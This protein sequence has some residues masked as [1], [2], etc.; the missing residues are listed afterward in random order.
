MPGITFPVKGIILISAAGGGSQ[1]SGM[2]LAGGAVILVVM[3]M[4]RIRSRQAQARCNQVTPEEKIASLRKEASARDRVDATM[5]EV[6]EV[7]RECVARLENKAL[8]LEHLLDLAEQRIREMNQL[9]E[10]QQKEQAHEQVTSQPSEA[11]VA[12]R[13]GESM[14]NEVAGTVPEKE[15]MQ[16]DVIQPV[17]AEPADPL[18][19]QI[20]EMADKGATPVQIAKE[21]DEQVGKVELI[22]ALRRAG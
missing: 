1:L 7:T 10:S 6:V 22:L 9:L 5:S 14:H 19:R 4:M 18:T 15:V 12:E 17:M 11:A 21:L 8:R 13:N 2:L 16:K 3:M 20:Y